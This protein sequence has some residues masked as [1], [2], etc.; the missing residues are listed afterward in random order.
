MSAW[1]D[2]GSGSLPKQTLKT[3]SVAEALMSPTHE[4]QNAREREDARKRRHNKKEP[5]EGE[6]EKKKEPF[7][8][9]QSFDN[10]GRELMSLVAT[11]LREIGI[12]RMWRP[13]PRLTKTCSCPWLRR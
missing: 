12:S 9:R 10:I 3:L 1:S 13:R 5:E 4:E 7:I 6:D 8:I 11:A 2:M